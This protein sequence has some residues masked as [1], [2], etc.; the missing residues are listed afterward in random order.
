MEQPDSEV[1]LEAFA[2]KTASLMQRVEKVTQQ[3]L[4]QQQK[5]QQYSAAMLQSF[6]ESY[7]AWLQQYQ[8]DPARMV[9]RQIQYCQDWSRFDQ[10]PQHTN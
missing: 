8:Q 3:W 10:C 1:L 7:L 9:N 4:S 6:S 2:E 5:T